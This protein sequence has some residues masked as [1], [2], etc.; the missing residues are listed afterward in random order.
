MNSIPAR[1]SGFIGEEIHLDSI[2]LQT[3]RQQ[4]VCYWN[5]RGRKLEAR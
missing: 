5:T 2:E 1:D 3:Q 4:I